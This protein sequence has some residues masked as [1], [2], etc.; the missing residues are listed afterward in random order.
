[1]TITVKDTGIGIAETQISERLFQPFRQMDSVPAL[2]FASHQK[3]ATTRKY[4]GT[5]LGLT[6]SKRLAELMGGTL[7][8]ESELDVG[9]TFTFEFVAD[10]CRV[11]SYASEN[12][13]VGRKSA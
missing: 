4:G 1:M 8:V 9:S 12:D 7:F 3:K 11:S 2:V 13:F 10:I 5:G 6:I